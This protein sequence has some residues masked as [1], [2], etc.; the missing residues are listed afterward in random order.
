MEKKLYVGI[1]VHSKEHSAAII[2]TSLFT[3]GDAAWKRIK[4]IKIINERSSF[5]YLNKIIR[6]KVLDPSE[7]SIVVDHTGG[8]YSEPIVFF[9]TTQCYGVYFVESKGL[10]A[11]R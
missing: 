7:V 3:R 9:L 1:D 4:T 8:H 5:E 10:K 2:P 6:S 11:A